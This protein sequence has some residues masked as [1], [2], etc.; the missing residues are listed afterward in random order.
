MS[1]L[2]TVV[3]G[4][5]LGGLYCLYAT[6]L[7]LI[8]G[9]MRV[10][11]LAHGALTL[12]ATYLALVAVEHTGISPLVALLLVAPVMFGMGYVIQRL[13]VNFSMGSG[14]LP[15]LLITFGLAVVIENGLLKGFTADSRGLGWSSRRRGWRAKAWTFRLR[16]PGASRC[17]RRS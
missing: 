3:Q 14:P 13:L 5:L 7:S 2:D 1:W 12:L 4:I 6:G 15:P 8:F 10:V 11:N 17:S 9:V 16:M